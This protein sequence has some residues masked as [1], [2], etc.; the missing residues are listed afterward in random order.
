MTEKQILRKIFPIYRSICKNLN[1]FR[2]AVDAIEDGHNLYVKKAFMLG[3]LCLAEAKEL[4]RKYPRPGLLLCYVAVETLSNCLAYFK[5]TKGFKNNNFK[6]N[7]RI[8]N[9]INKTM[10][11]CNF[12]NSHCPKPLIN[13]I[14]FKKYVNNSI[15]QS[16]FYEFLRYLYQKS[17]S[18]AVHK[19]I[20][21]TLGSSNSFSDVYINEK[22]ENCYVA[23]EIKGNTLPGWLFKVAC[24]SFKNF[25]NKEEIS[26]SPQS[27]TPLNNSR[28]PILR[29]PK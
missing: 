15:K 25:L 28:H 7:Y 20:F 11:F 10:E 2:E 22:G 4:K 29:H 21:R 5:K 9:T 6:E 18:Y 23:I 26:T 13:K 14:R 27:A 12:L 16:D 1:A 8:E 17:R 24:G 3:S 19:G